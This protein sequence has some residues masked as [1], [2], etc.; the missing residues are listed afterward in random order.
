MTIDLQT[1]PV[2]S[3]LVPPVPVPP[4]RE[5]ST[6]RFIATMRTNGIGC[7]PASAYEVPLRRR[8]RRA[9]CGSP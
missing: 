5:L 9:R 8:R 2:G 6:L 7:W 1:V 4:E 3:R